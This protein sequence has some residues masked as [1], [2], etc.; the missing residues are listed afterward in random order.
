MGKIIKDIVEDTFIR[1]NTNIYELSILMGVDSFDYMVTDSR[2]HVQAVKSYDAGPQQMAQPSIL[3]SLIQEH[4]LL[5][6][7]YRA[8]RAGWASG[9]S[10]L[11]PQRLYNEQKKTAYLEQATELGAGEAILVDSLPDLALNNVYA[12]PQAIVSFIRQSFPACRLF[13]ISTALLACIRNLPSPKEGHRVYA[14]LK[15][16]LVFISV[17]DGS[18]L[19]FLNAFPYQSAK[20]FI[21]FLL[22]SYQQL[23]LKQERAPAYLSGQLVEDSEI[24]REAFRYLKNIHFA[25]LPP[26]FQLGDKLSKEPKHF[27]FGLSGLSLCG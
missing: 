20:D 24:Y 6:L 13:H 21:Y 5:T 22:L 4:G 12:V 25:E 15:D 17:F 11:V 3:Q 7:P 19:L 23:G 18:S 27:F 26:F 1:K 14:H 2:Q 8:V 10:T 16:G 9:K